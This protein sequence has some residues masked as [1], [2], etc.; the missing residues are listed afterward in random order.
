MVARILVPGRNGQFGSACCRNSRS[1]GHEVI[2]VHNYG[3]E[4]IFGGE[5]DTEQN[6]DIH[7]DHD[8][9]AHREMD[10]LDRELAHLFRQDFSNFGAGDDCDHIF[11]FPGHSTGSRKLMSEGRHKTSRMSRLTFSAGN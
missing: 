2:S 6:V 4:G 10:M 7:L 1:N 5:E 11:C 9:T 3:R 8:Q